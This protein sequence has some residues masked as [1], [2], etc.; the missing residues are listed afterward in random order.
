MSESQLPVGVHSSIAAWLDHLEYKYSFSVVARAVSYL[1]LSRVG[2]TESELADLLSKAHSDQVAQVDVERLLLDLKRFLTTTTVIGCQVLLWMSRHFGLVV[3]KTYL[4]TCEARK[5]IHSEL[6]DYFLSRWNTRLEKSSLNEGGAR[7]REYVNERP[8]LREV[9]HAR[10][11][12]ELMHHFRESNNLEL[13]WEMLTSWRFHRVLVKAGLLKALVAMLRQE[14]GR[15]CALLASTLAS[16]SCFLQSS[17]SELPTSMEASLLPYVELFP[18]FVA[19]V[20][21]IRWERRSRGCGLAVALPPAPDTVALLR[22]VKCESGPKRLTAAAAA[23]TQCGTIAKVMCDGSAW[24]WNGSS[25]AAARRSPISEQGELKFA[26]VKSSRRFMLFSTRC[27]KLFLW[28]ATAPEILTEI[29]TSRTLTMLAGFVTSERRQCAWWKQ[30]SLVGLFDASDTTVKDLR[31]PSC[32]T[33]VVFCSDGAHVFCGQ[34]D[35]TVSIFDVDKYSLLRSC[36]N[37]S[38][39]AIVSIILCE[40]KQEMACVERSG[41]VKLWNVPSETQTPTLVKESFAG[42]KFNNML[43]ID[44]PDEFNSLLVCHGNQIAVWDTCE[45]ERCDRFLATRG[46]AFVQAIFSKGGHH[47]LAFLEARPLVLVWQVNTGQCVLS[48]E[49]HTLPHTL[50]KTTSDIVCVTDDGCLLAWDSK[51]FFLAGETPKMECG[52]QDVAAG[53][54][55]RCFYTSDGT[56]TVWS[57][58]LETG[59]PHAH[60]LHGHPVQ[61]IRLSRDDVTLVTLS[62]EDIYIWHPET[63]QNILRIGG[64]GATDVLITPNCHFGVSIC[65]RGLSRVWRMSHGGVVCDIHLHLSSAQVSAESTFLI[66]LHGGNLLAASLWSGTISKSFRRVE[67]S[68]DVVAFGTLSQHADF[69]VVVGASGAIYTWKMSDETVCRHFQLPRTFYC[70]PE[71]FRMTSDGS[72]ALLSIDNDAINLLDMSQVRL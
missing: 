45:W 42:S 1:T 67:S 25:F 39:G 69:V 35:G 5:E 60:F 30:D 59:L 51:M 41:D 56:H 55:G 4:D 22:H 71:N 61:K 23:A 8:T 52:V 65:E 38:H 19:Y 18:A 20:G 6:A 66:G 36:S 12:V 7:A 21:E 32:V 29:K 3:E 63:G 50:L 31:C 44:Y 13:R 48:L 28:D 27:N 47:F 17:P 62:A 26:G 40:D 49:V 43:N 54:T 24:M 57:W 34:E 58:S 11:A 9:V 37:S 68:E 33:C 15:E 14:C 70:Q 46:Q 10:E 53:R 64:G 72:F 2:L 16:S